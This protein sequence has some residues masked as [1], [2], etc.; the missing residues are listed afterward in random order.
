MKWTF[1]MMENGKFLRFGIFIG[2][3]RI[4]QKRISLLFAISSFILPSS[5][6]LERFT[7][8][9]MTWENASLTWTKRNETNSNMKML[10]SI[11]LSNPMVVF[12]FW[13]I[14]KYETQFYGSIPEKSIEI[15]GY[16]IK[17]F[18]LTK[19]FAWTDF[20]H[21]IESMLY[22]S[23]CSHIWN[24]TKFYKFYIRFDTPIHVKENEW[25]TTFITSDIF[26]QYL[27]NW[28]GFNLR[29]I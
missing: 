7:K 14:S 11:L 26:E 20:K 8:I 29:N 28:Y 1:G 19:Q 6:N 4:S 9:S 13:L 12:W 2:S 22:L 21:A 27:T 17:I 5:K 15:L 24:Y 10:T 3:L 23:S 18:L 25:R 16:C